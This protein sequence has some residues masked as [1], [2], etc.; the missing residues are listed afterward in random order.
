MARS[1]YSSPAGRAE[2]FT[3]YEQAIDDLGVQVDRL[4][5]DTRF[6]HTYVLVAGPESAPPLVVFHGGN[7]LGPLS[8]A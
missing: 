5:V 8:M 1:I 6:G 3:L 2:V 4:S 7:F